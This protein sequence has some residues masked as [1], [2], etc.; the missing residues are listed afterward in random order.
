M[1]LATWRGSRHFMLDQHTLKPG[2]RVRIVADP[3]EVRLRSNTGA[4]ARPDKYSDYYVIVLDEPA[5]Y[6]DADG[7]DE[8]LSEIVEHIDNL[9]VLS[10]PS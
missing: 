3:V 7:K 4:V 5:R 10:Q 6:D 9:I 2:T 8:E 1:S